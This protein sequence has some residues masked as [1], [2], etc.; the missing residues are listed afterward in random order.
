MQDNKIGHYFY[1]AGIFFLL[2]LIFILGCLFIIL[3]GPSKV[4]GDLLTVSCLETSA[5]KF[6][7][8]IFL[9]DKEISDVK[10]RNAVINSGEIT[11]TSFEFENETL[12]LSKIEIIDIKGSTFKGKL[13][14]VN[15]PAR[16]KI[17]TI[18]VYGSEL[19]GKKV[20]DFVKDENAIAG[21][22]GGGFSDL[23]GLGLGG[24]PLGLV[25]KDSKI[26]NGTPAR[27]DTLVGFDKNNKLIVGKM[28]GQAALD[29]NMRD[30]IAFEP[31][32]I[33]NGKPQKVSGYGSGVNPRTVIGQR[34]DGAVLLLVIDGRQSHSLGAT[35]QDCIDVMLEYGAYN[36]ANLDGGSSSILVYDGKILNICASLYGSRR[37]PTAFI[38]SKE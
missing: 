34:K 38:V 21:I 25:I 19:K 1:I 26:I 9:S 17:A 27:T 29:M 20:E 5:L 6:I 11:D 36:A 30:A 24:M 22:N 33:V 15:N 3:K 12:D 8:K 13:M 7:P 23:N 32:F 31:I 10:E 16:I 2:I 37:I 35:Y 28:T 4:A 18:P 14:I